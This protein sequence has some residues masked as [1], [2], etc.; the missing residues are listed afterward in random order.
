M[1]VTLSSEE[2][3]LLMEVLEERHRELLREL[4]RTK[5]HEF[6]TILSYKEKLL[7]SVL[8]KL[9]IAESVHA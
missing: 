4:A 5:H 7:E 2:E 8:D 9:R 3:L 6:K 1:E